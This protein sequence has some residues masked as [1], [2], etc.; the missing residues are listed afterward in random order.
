MTR[1]SEKFNKPT[2]VTSS[3]KN[4][5][6]RVHKPTKKTKKSISRPK[7]PTTVICGF[8][9]SG[10]TTLLNH[11][12][13][14]RQGYK[15]A[16][17]VNDMSE[18]SIDAAI[19]KNGQ[20]SLKR[21]EEK[22]V[23]LANGCICCT[24]REDLVKEVSK[25]ARKGKFD[26]LLIESTGMAEPLPIA[27][28]FSFQD[29]HGKTLYEIAKIDTMVTVVDAYNFYN[30]LNSI[31][32]VKE[33]VKIGKNETKM[34]EIPIAQLFIDQVEFANVII[35]NKTDLVDKEKLD[36][37][38]NLISKLNPTA[39]I[40][41]SNHSKIP[42]EKILMTEKFDF[43]E[44][45][46]SAKWIEELAKGPSSEV[47][48]Y[49]FSSF[50]FRSRKPF[51]PEKLFELMK[52]ASVFKSVV[53]AKGYI[54]VATNMYLCAT[55]NIVGDLITLDPETIWWAAIKKNKWGETVKE[56]RLVEDAVK[57]IWDPVYGDRRIELVFIGKT[58]DKEAIVEKLDG[59]LLTD[60]EF[61]LGDSEWRKMFTDPFTEWRDVVREHPMRDNFKE[62]DD[63]WEDDDSE[64][65]K[66]EK[67]VVSYQDGNKR[68]D[69]FGKG[70]L[71][72][73]KKN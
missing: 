28:A 39:E 64:D 51:D 33:E 35:I 66:W 32:T 54:W 34:Q 45:Q 43:E 11:I 13:N 14:N 31:E 21:T 22:L 59:C 48:E 44:A 49:G 16:V 68:K 17:I 70:N 61:K 73:K 56:R 42:L 72:K 19:V 18:V 26:Y 55:F 71:K 5:H 6:S 40:I 3:H 10:K 36:S 65:E 4:N 8:L 37:I 69:K 12:L 52:H 9:G 2:T 58:M 25:L 15:V 29:D 50:V 47:D 46:N 30:Q 1:Q 62:L 7:L 24:L 60:D 38:V 20:A 27:Q 23:E 53:R 67:V 57:D 63:G 41:F